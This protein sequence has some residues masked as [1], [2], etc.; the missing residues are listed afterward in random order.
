MAA[1]ALV[2]VLRSARVAQVA[3]AAGPPPSS[4]IKVWW[5]RPVVGLVALLITHFR[6]DTTVRPSGSMDLRSTLAVV[7]PSSWEVAVELGVLFV[8]VLAAL[9]FGAEAE[10]EA[11]S[12]RPRVGAADP[13]VAGGPLVNTMVIL[14]TVQIPEVPRAGVWDPTPRYTVILLPL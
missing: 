6:Q 1:V 5:Q 11:I 7:L 13:E 12:F 8:V 9:D 4:S 2:D 3:A 14:F 10:V